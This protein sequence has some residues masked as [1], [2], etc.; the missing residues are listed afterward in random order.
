MLHELEKQDFHKVL[1]LVSIVDHNRAVIDAVVQGNNAGRVFVDNLFNPTAALVYPQEMVVYL[2]SPQPTNA[3]L[4]DVQELL[5]GDWNVQGVEL[6]TYPLV[7]P[8]QLDVLL[9]GRPHVKLVRRDYKLN[10]EKFAKMAGNCE[11][12]P[13]SELTLCGIDS[14]FFE[15]FPVELMPGWG[16]AD[17]LRHGFGY[18][19]VKGEELISQCVVGFRSNDAV[20]LSVKTNEDYRRQGL[21]L[22]VCRAVLEHALAKGLTPTW[23]CWD[24]NEASWRLGEKLGFDL[25]STKQLFLW[26]TW[27]QKKHDSEK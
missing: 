9:G 22:P 12:P 5:F 2:I 27:V 24:F 15:A 25:A 7:Q 26:D 19:L 10:M 6:L 4:E 23:S 3:F 13:A 18:S 17:F 11:L 16:K 8:E 20:E 14:A 1:D 21:A